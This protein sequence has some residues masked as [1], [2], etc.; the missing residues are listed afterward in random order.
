MND[1]KTLDQLRVAYEAEKYACVENQKYYVSTEFRMKIGLLIVVFLIIQYLVI[2]MAWDVYATTTTTTTLDE[3]YESFKSGRWL[4]VCSTMQ[5][6]YF[7]YTIFMEM[8]TDL[9]AFHRLELEY[10]EAEI[11]LSNQ[12]KETEKKEQP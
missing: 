11:R 12:E 10:E 2:Q 6:M 7:V 9:T 3:S 1:A 4:Y 8:Y 5:F